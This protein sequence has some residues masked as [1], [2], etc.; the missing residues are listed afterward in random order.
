MNATATAGVRTPPKISPEVLSQINVV[1]GDLSDIADQQLPPEP[2]VEQPGQ[3][4]E[5]KRALPRF[6]YP[7]DPILLIEGAKASF[8]DLGVLNQA[9]GSIRTQ[10]YQR[11]QEAFK[12]R[13]P[14]GQAAVTANAIFSETVSAGNAKAKTLRKQIDRLLGKH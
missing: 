11:T 9:E 12:V 5:V 3:W 8:R 4:V 14:T 7:A 2:V 6:F 13:V 10:I 1:K